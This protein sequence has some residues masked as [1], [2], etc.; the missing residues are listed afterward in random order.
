M[1]SLLELLWRAG[2]VT[3]RRYLRFTVSKPL[4]ISTKMNNVGDAVILRNT[5][6]N[7]SGCPFF[8]ERVAFVP[9]APYT[10]SDLNMMSAPQHRNSH[11]RSLVSLCR[12]TD[13][14]VTFGVASGSSSSSDSDALVLP[15]PFTESD[16][17]AYMRHQDSRC[18][19]CVSI[20]LL[21]IRLDVFICALFLIYIF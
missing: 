18:F 9:H 10:C 14:A 8:F 12:T 2:L 13:V 17:T 3:R 5:I 16:A 6:V 1:S 19:M 15:A 21:C 7:K 4:S 11:S 20:C